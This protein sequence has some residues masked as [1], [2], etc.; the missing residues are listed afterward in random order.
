MVPCHSARDWRKRAKPIQLTFA[1]LLD[2]EALL[3]CSMYVNLNPIRAGKVERPEES[4]YTSAFERPSNHCGLTSSSA[5]TTGVED[6]SRKRTRY[7]FAAAL[8]VCPVRLAPGSELVPNQLPN[9]YPALVP[10]TGATCNWGCLT[11]FACSIGRVA[12]YDGTKR[13]RFLPPWHQS[14]SAYGWMLTNGLTRS[15][16]CADC[17]VPLWGGRRRLTRKLSARTVSGSRAYA[18]PTTAL[19]SRRT[20]PV[21]TMSAT[22]SPSLPDQPREVAWPLGC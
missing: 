16:E 17:C 12:K 3:A 7:G 20:A 15:L 1:P 10:P 19:A 8:S 11:T 6:S 22:K 2:D 9:A 18:L 21:H 13:G 4:Q 14:S 5:A